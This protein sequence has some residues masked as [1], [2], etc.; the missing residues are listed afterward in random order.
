MIG[1]INSKNEN[2]AT[3]FDKIQNWIDA[4]NLG[5]QPNINIDELNNI[6]NISN[7]NEY[8]V[9]E[10]QVFI[11]ELLK[12]QMHISTQYNECKTIFDFANDSISYIICDI[13]LYDSD[14]YLKPEEKYYKKIKKSDMCIELN[15]LKTMA[16]SRLNLMESKANI[17][18]KMIDTIN[19][20]V[21]RK[22][23]K[24]E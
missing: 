9:E 6:I 8:S 10:L 24:N 4:N 12:Y 11:Y 15:R 20:S 13:Q 7:L 17:I 1:E 21:K 14:K 23:Y 19:Y 18:N 22:G 5:V 16:A 3:F 2:I